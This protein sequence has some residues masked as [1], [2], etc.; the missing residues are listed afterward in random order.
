MIILICIVIGFLS[1]CSFISHSFSQL[2]LNIESGNYSVRICDIIFLI[3][4]IS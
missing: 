4:F 3:L 1:V 2:F